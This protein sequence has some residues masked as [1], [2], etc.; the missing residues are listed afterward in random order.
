MGF[1]LEQQ[2]GNLETT[3]VTFSD[4]PFFWRL[5]KV[6]ICLLVWNIAL[7]K[8]EDYL[9]FFPTP[10]IDEIFVHFSHFCPPYPKAHFCI[11]VSSSTSYFLIFVLLGSFPVLFWFFSYFFGVHV[12]FLF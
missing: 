10:L 9:I 4:D 1:V 11:G 5:F 3:G 8:F 6:S 12:L 2:F 7:E